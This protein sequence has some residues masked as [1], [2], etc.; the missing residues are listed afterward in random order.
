MIPHNPR[1]TAWLFY[2]IKYNLNKIT[3][4][5]RG[6][7]IK[8]ITKGNLEDFEFYAPIDLD[9]FELIDTFT[10]INE[11]V[12]IYTQENYKLSILRD[13]LLPKLMS[14]EIDVSEVEI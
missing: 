11:T 6:S 12:D 3:S 1:Y 8:F 10:K 13:T 9:S 5:A 2:A 7:V 14:G 4:A